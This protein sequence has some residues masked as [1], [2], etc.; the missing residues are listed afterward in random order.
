M[1]QLSHRDVLA[2]SQT[3]REIYACIDVEDIPAHFLLILQKIIPFEFASYDEIN[4]QAQAG[5]YAL[6]PSELLTPKNTET[7]ERH[8]HEHPF[9]IYFIKTHARTDAPQPVKLSD[10]ISK[11]CFHRT[12]LYN[13]F[14]RPWGIE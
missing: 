8:M 7:F 6:A 14:Y 3:M 9:L 5:M 13:E 1:E 10:L 12:G 11:A 2:L 4:L